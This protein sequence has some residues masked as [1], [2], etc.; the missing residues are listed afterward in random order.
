MEKSL[1]WFRFLVF[2]TNLRPDSSYLVTRMWFIPISVFHISHVQ[3]F[4]LLSSCFIIMKL[5][6]KHVINKYRSQW[7]A[8][9]T[10][11][12]VHCFVSPPCSA[13]RSVGGPCVSDQ[14]CEAIIEIRSKSGGGLKILQRPS[15]LYQSCFQGGKC[16][17]LWLKVLLIGLLHTFGSKTRCVSVEQRFSF[18]WFCIKLD[19]SI[20]AYSQ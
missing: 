17:E 9:L 16:A 2:H 3:I 10:V 20:Q 15:L 14:S 13:P 7:K 4:H 19:K 12:L 8:E 18:S 5:W 6:N 1:L 11:T